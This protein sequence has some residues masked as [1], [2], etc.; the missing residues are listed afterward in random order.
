MYVYLTE[1]LPTT[2]G[3]TEAGYHHRSS[4]EKIVRWMRFTSG[5]DRESWEKERDAL[6]E[7]ASPKLAFH[8]QP[9]E[10]KLSSYEPMYPYFEV[11]LR[12][13][14]KTEKGFQF[15]CN[16]AEG[17]YFIPGCVLL[18][19]GGYSIH[20]SPLPPEE[21]EK[22]LRSAEVYEDEDNLAFQKALLRG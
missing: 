21:F 10:D 2:Y 16:V 3:L 20:L 1:V 12:N 22:S 4:P 18:L 19:N 7:Q 13:F 6:V 11:D 17:K 8:L 15:L 9:N 5:S 14:C